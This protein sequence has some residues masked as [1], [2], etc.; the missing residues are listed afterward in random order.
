MAE[1][2]AAVGAA[3]AAAVQAGSDCLHYFNKVIFILKESYCELI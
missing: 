2:Q 1:V 3:R